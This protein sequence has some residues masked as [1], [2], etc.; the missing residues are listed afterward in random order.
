MAT[1]AMMN[2]T[3]NTN[4]CSAFMED[5]LSKIASLVFSLL[6]SVLLFPLLFGIVW[7]ERFGTDFRRNLNNRLMSAIIWRLIGSLVALHYPNWIQVRSYY[8]K[9]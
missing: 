7:F 1:T 3:L 5:N 4:F 9:H 6:A 8:F 2:Q